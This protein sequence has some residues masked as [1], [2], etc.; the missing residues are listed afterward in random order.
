MEK[1]DELIKGGSDIGRPFWTALSEGRLDLPFCNAC[2][3]AFFYPRAICPEC[4]SSDL[5]WKTASG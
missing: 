4:W 5:G 2:K 1:L 3:R